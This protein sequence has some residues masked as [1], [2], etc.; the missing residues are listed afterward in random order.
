M[1]IKKWLTTLFIIILSSVAVLLLIMILNYDNNM[2]LRIVG[3]SSNGRNYTL[4]FPE[5]VTLQDPPPADELIEYMNDKYGVT[6]QRYNG[7]E[8]LI[9]KFETDH[10]NANDFAELYNGILVETDEYPNHYFY[11]CSYYGSYLDDYCFHNNQ[12]KIDNYFNDKLNGVIDSNYKVICHPKFKQRYAVDFSSH[13]SEYINHCNYDIRIFIE[14]DG[15]NAEKELEEILNVLKPYL[16]EYDKQLFL[17]YVDSAQ[18]NAVDSTDY[19]SYLHDKI[20]YIKYG[21]GEMLFYENENPLVW[22]WVDSEE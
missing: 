17:Y 9:D 5:L 15:K 16:N 10:I 3:D 4:T 14:N 2:I 1:K 19:N 8:Y 22:E 18:F 12:W 13:T 7:E 21:Q 20:T 6:F 11:V